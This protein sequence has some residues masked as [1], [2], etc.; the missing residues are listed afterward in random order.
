MNLEYQV[1][2]LENGLTCIYVPMDTPGS[3]CSNIIYKIGSAN[4]R[5]GE[6]GLAHFWEHLF[7]KGSVKYNK[8]TPGGCIT[9]LELKGG[10][11]NATTSFFRTNYFLTVP[12]NFIPDVISREADRMRGIDRQLLI[13]GLGTECTVVENEL[14]RGKGNPMRTMMAALNKNAYQKEKIRDSTI[15]GYESLEQSVKDKG[16]ALERYFKRSYTPDNAYY[17]LAG[18]FNEQTF[19]IDQLHDQVER[20]FGSITTGRLDANE[21]PEEPPQLG[22]KTFTIPGDTTMCAM[23]FKGPKG[24]HSDS[25]A[26]TALS[27][28]MKGRMG[29]LEER[30][31]CMQS[32]VM[33]DRALQSSLF[34]L[35]TVGFKDIDAVRSAMMNVVYEIQTSKPISS[36]ELNKAKIDLRNGWIAQLQSAQGVA[37]AF[38]EAVAM[39]NANDVNTKFEKLD[40]LSPADLSQAASHWLVD[41]GLTMGIMYPYRV[42]EAHPSTAFIPKLKNVGSRLTGDVISPPR[43]DPSISF[44]RAHHL[45]SSGSEPSNVPGASWK[46]P[47]MVQVS[48]TFTPKVDTEWF[49]MS[50]SSLVKDPHISWRSLGPGV[51]MATYSGMPEELNTN[52]LE[53]IWGDKRGYMTAGQK[54][55]AMQQGIAYDPNKY[56][57]KL[58][59]NSI[60]NLPS[61]N[62]SLTNAISIVKNSPRRVVTVAPEDSMLSMVRNYFKHDSQYEEY[63][64]PASLTP[65]SITV[66]QN[67]DSVNVL[68]GQALHG[69]GRNHNDFIP[70]NIATAVLGY[71]FHGMLMTRVRIQDGLTYGIEAHISPGMFQVGATFPPRNLER[72]VNDIKAV[73]ADWR[74]SITKQEFKVQKERLK[75]MPVT[76][77]DNPATYVKAQHTFLGENRINA[78]SYKDV[79]DA[80]DK[81]I[82]INKLVQIRVG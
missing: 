75:L 36:E 45:T 78:C 59:E 60:F 48:V 56:S 80:F 22:M 62:H 5:P 68:F 38:T 82:D 9:D 81:H 32:E 50:M 41:T 66:P 16:A 12:V 27:N 51:V 3:A 49:A 74:S 1:R 76:L 57:V 43:F 11:E 7:H 30:G 21:Y 67:K 69:I 17:V 37:D 42:N 19:T 39:G 24:I 29:A 40:A 55:K 8:N 65:K 15:G 79:L 31:I 58:L 33:W 34:S 18:P 61:Y 77:S 70:L 53:A 23:G 64:P 6:E 26:L 25:I 2:N 71:G 13:A 52:S 4:E 28:C 72:G 73:L 10:I 20:E 63:V 14:E 54:G 44:D 47:G 35:W 46:R